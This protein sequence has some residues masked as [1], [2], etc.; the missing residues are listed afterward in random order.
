MPRTR[1]IEHEGVRILEIDFSG[2]RG[3]EYLRRIDEVAAV[4]RAQPERSLL[5]LTIVT[6]SEYSAAMMDVLRPYIAGNK[7]YVLAGAVVTLDHLQKVVAPVNRLTGRDL[8]TFDDVESAREWLV[9]QLR[10]DG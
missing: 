2:C 5:T 1:F 3:E 8:Q 10:R 9:T 7:P 6:G 4:I